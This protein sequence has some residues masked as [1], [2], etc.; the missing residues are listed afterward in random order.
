M[1]TDMTLLL[2]LVQFCMKKKINGSHFCSVYFSFLSSMTHVSYEFCINQHNAEQASQKSKL[3]I[4]TRNNKI[5]LNMFN[6]LIIIIGHS[7]N[8]KG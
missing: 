8:F 3:H 4:H 1:L 6:T 7:P 2:N 5:F